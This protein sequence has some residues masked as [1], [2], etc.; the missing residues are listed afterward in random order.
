MTHQPTPGETDQLSD[1]D[2]QELRLFASYLR[3]RAAARDG[4]AVDSPELLYAVVYG[5][6]TSEDE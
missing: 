4:D 2:A 5:Q 6:P 1:G 3:G